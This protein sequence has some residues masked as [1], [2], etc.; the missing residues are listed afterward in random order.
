[1]DIALD[2]LR[3]N[4][5]FADLADEELEHVAREGRQRE[6]AAGEVVSRAGDHDAS[7]FIVLEGRL[8]ALRMVLEED[9]PLATVGPGQACGEMSILTGQPRSA[10]LIAEEPSQVLELTLPS[11][12]RLLGTHPEL[13]GRLWRNLAAVLAER[14]HATTDLL[15]DVVESHRHLLEQAEVRRRCGQL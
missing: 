9:V 4:G 6:F 2:R 10:A 5:I 3:G 11:L 1:M 12:E 15:T 14:L 8:A 13:A 7:L